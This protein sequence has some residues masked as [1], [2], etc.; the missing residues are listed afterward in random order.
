MP[1]KEEMKVMRQR[2]CDRAYKEIPKAGDRPI[3]INLGYGVAMGIINSIT[4]NHRS[5]IILQ[6]ESCIIGMDEY[7]DEDALDYTLDN[8]Y[9]HVDPAGLPV[10]VNKEYGCSTKSVADS[11]SFINSGKIFATFLGAYEV[12]SYG[13]LANWA[14]SYDHAAGA[15]GAM[16]LCANAQNV[17][18][19][20]MEN[21]KDGKSKL[22]EKTEMPIT[23]PKCVVKVFT[24]KGVYE[25]NNGE[26][27]KLEEWSDS[28][29]D[30]VVLK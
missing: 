12:D 3:V 18:I 26:W 16:E 27:K 24:E 7:I 29:N 8:N 25:P 19:C 13:N 20:M 14:V 15:G 17:Y 28:V 9:H 1:T 30:Y 21:T 5:D 10:Y 4:K 2:I 6:G 22:V 23:Y 11:F